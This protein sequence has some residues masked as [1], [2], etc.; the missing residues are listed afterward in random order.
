VGTSVSESSPFKPT[1][2]SPWY[3]CKNVETITRLIEHFRSN[4]HKWP[5]YDPQDREWMRAAN[6]LG[7]SDSRTRVWTELSHTSTS[8]QKRGSL[9]GS[10]L[11][12]MYCENSARLLEELP[13]DVKMMGILGSDAAI[14]LHP[15]VVSLNAE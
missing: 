11:A 2:S 7:D 12:L 5:E 8:Y 13:D 3:N 9:Y 10:I 6:V 4:S 14:L 1:M 15:A